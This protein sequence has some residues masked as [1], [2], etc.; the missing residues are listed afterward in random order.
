MLTKGNPMS[1]TSG[2][3]TRKSPMGVLYSQIGYD[4]GDPV[5]LILRGNASMLPRT[6]EKIPV[7]RLLSDES[8]IDCSVTYWGAIWESH[9]W[10]ADLQPAMNE[11]GRYVFEI[12]N[13]MITDTLPFEKS[14]FVSDNWLWRKTW[15]HVGLNQAERRQI[16]ARGGVGWFDAGMEWMEAS[17]HAAYIV[18]FLDVLQHAAS[19]ITPEERARVEKQVLNGCDYLAILQDLAGK[20]PDQSGGIVHQ[21]WKYDDVVLGSDTTKAAVCWARAA[22]LLSGA[23]AGKKSEYKDR[24]VRAMAFM[25]ERAKP[26]GAHGFHR[27]FHGAADD[28]VVP[29]EWMTR[30]L[31]QHLW[32]ATELVQAGEPD[33]LDEAVALAEQVMARQVPSSDAAKYDGL[34]GHFRTFATGDLIEQAWCHNLEGKIAGADTGGHFPHWVVPLLYLSERYPDHPDAPRWRECVRDFA[35]GYFLPACSRNPFYLLPQGWYEGEGLVWFAGLWHGMNAAYGLAAALAWEFERSF[36]DDAFRNVFTGNVQWIAGLNAGI[37]RDSLKGSVL[38]DTEIEPGVAMPVSL[39]HGIGARSA[40]CW[41]NIKGAIGNGF[42]TGAQFKFDV[43]P[44]QVNDAPSSFTD[45]DWISHAGAWLS[46]LARRQ[47]R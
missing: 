28:Y 17:S 9:W 24:A 15:Q 36:E 37:T 4:A 34:Y 18:G 47:S 20:L 39:I 29:D 33:F 6:G 32:A 35:Y 1:N 8:P 25:R 19:A 7:H 5:R 22:R 21:S 43:P 44:T 27:Q 46:A 12:E 14:F 45:E 11:S 26:C 42:A 40:G 23:H 10:I 16:F 31:L 30:D 38:F 41:L 2:N 13:R 3:Q